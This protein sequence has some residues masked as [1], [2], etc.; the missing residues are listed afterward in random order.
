ML[1]AMSP[2]DVSL[3]AAGRNVVKL[4]ALSNHTLAL[5]AKAHSQLGPK[6]SKRNLNYRFN[7]QDSQAEGIGNHQGTYLTSPLIHRRSQS[8]MATAAKQQQVQPEARPTIQ[9]DGSKIDLNTGN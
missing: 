7:S 5:E 1:S 6:T 4:T 8:P 3:G 9:I 2:E